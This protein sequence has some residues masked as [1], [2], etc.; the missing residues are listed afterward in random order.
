MTVELILLLASLLL[1]GSV[2]ASKISSRLGIPVLLVFLGIGM[3]AGVDGLGGIAFDD[4]ILTQNLAIIALTVI[5]FSGGLDTDWVRVRPV[6]KEASILATLGV[7]LTAGLVAVFARFFLGYNWLEGLLLGSIVASTDA[8]AVFSVL[9][10]RGVSLKGGSDRVL[11]L[12]SGSNDPMAVFLTVAM[13]AVLAVPGSISALGFLGLFLKQMLVGGALG[14]LLGRLGSELINRAQLEYDG[15]YPPFLLSWALLS[16]ALPALL[17]GSGFLAVYL[18]GI[19]IANRPLVH[20]KSLSGFFDGLAWL[21]QIAMFLVL[22]LLVFPSRLTPL[23]GSALALSAFLILVARPIAVFFS[24]IGSGRSVHQKTFIAWVGLRGAVPIILATYPVVAGLELADEMFHLVFFVVLTSVLLQGTTLEPAARWL[25]LSQPN[26]DGRPAV[27]SF[28]PSMPT[29]S[30]L[31][32]IEVLADAPAVGVPL[33]NLDLPKGTLIVLIT[34][35]HGYTVPTG[36]TRLEPGDRAL[37]LA[38]PGQ[39]VEVQRL[40]RGPE[41]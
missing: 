4:A 21:M 8:A 16:Y 1:L 36:T 3:M 14:L 32:E 2:L 26:R 41:D 22:G 38:E 25:G 27:L 28:E 13:T 17:G 19:V 23:V 7:G 10:S 29:E 15:L 5:L 31:E 30:R 9:K 34:R 37:V 11:E 12:E 35:Q 6:L 20:R 24:L 39:V 18:V 33:L 40:L